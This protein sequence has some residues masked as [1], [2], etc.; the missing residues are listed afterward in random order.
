MGVANVIPHNERDHSLHNIHPGVSEFEQQSCTKADDW[1][2]E[3]PS[4]CCF[5]VVELLG[6]G[7]V[8]EHSAAVQPRPFAS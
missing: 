6:L 7:L 5:F 8:L 2:A 4:R 3:L 1:L